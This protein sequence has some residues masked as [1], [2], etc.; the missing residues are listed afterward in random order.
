MM[1]LFWVYGCMTPKG[2]VNRFLGQFKNRS[3]ERDYPIR[4]IQLAFASISSTTAIL[5]DIGILGWICLYFLRCFSIAFLLWDGIVHQ[6]LYKE[7][8]E[9]DRISP[10]RSNTKKAVSKTKHPLP[11]W[12][13]HGFTMVGFLGFMFKDNTTVL[14]LFTR[15]EIALVFMITMWFY[16]ENETLQDKKYDNI[17]HILAVFQSLTYFFFRLVPFGFDGFYAVIPHIRIWNP[18]SLIGVPG[19]AWIYFMNWQWFL[20]FT[21]K[22]FPLFGKVCNIVIQY[23]MTIK[24]KIKISD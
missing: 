6:D 8:E 22:T 17:R 10:P 1:S 18:V 24:S 2:K 11:I 21:G 5:F 4:T 20:K 16:L 9:A 3:Y 14:L 13:H 23:L 12:I 19:F 7:A 15:G